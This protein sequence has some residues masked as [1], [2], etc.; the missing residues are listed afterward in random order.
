MERYFGYAEPVTP[1][2]N[3]RVQAGQRV[4]V[5]EP[6]DFRHH[7]IE[8]I[9]HAIGFSHEGIEPTTPVH[10]VA[11]RVLVEQLGSAGARF[12]RRE[13]HHRQVITALEVM[14]RFLEGG[15]AFLVH[16]PG[17]RLGKIRVRIARSRSAL[18]LDEQGPAR[19][20]AAQRVV[21][22]RGCGDQLALR[23]AVQV[24]PAKTCRAL[25]RAI[26]VQHNAR[27]DQ[28]GPGKPVGQQRG[29]LAVFGKVQHG[30]PLTRPAAAC[31]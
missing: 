26:L 28:P 6:G 9:E 7:A 21:E 24:R 18:G 20:Q 10:A 31:A 5:I 3:R 2:R 14:A 1:R 15:A 23:G 8:Q 12:L 30:I 25:E 19:T 11:G 29:P 13:E 4:V 22:P 27:R 17:Q 16:Q